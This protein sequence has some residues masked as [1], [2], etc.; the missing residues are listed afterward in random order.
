MHQLVKD[1]AAQSKKLSERLEAKQKEVPEMEKLLQELAARNEMLEARL[2]H[3]EASSSDTSPAASPAL[4]RSPRRRSPRRTPVARPRPRKRAT[5]ES[6][7]DEEEP[8]KRRLSAQLATP[9]T[10]NK[11]P[12]VVREV[13]KILVE[14]LREND[15]DQKITSG[16]YLD[17]N[18]FFKLD[19]F[20]DDTRAI[21]D[22]IHTSEDIDSGSLSKVDIFQLAVKVAK[23]RERYTPKVKKRSNKDD[24]KK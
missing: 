12:A 7:V 18:R 20:E 19:L 22:Y 16:Y 10:R 24:K 2:Q 5:P 14:I 1:L 13:R 4:R 11:K 6:T 8:V 15:M 17:P 3:L 9:K 21:V 23:K